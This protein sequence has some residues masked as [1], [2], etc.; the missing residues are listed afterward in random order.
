MNK[1]K[2]TMREIGHRCYQSE[3][4]KQNTHDS[5][6]LLSERR[7][8]VW[9]RVARMAIRACETEDM[10]TPLKT[11]AAERMERLRR[12]RGI[13]AR[14]FTGLSPKQMGDADYMAA[15]RAISGASLTNSK[16]V[17]AGLAL[18]DLLPRS[19]AACRAGIN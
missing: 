5:W 8:Q 14:K 18:R 6:I 11:P 3:A 13:E 4:I 17:T 19:A 10:K 2:L 1:K 7:K 12:S 15:Y 16:T 9:I